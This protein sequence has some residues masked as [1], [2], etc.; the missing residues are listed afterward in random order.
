MKWSTKIKGGSLQ[1]VLFIGAV[2]AVLLLT[3]VLLSHMHIQFSKKSDTYIETIKQADL[4]L[5]MVLNNSNGGLVGLRD[6][7]QKGI[8]TDVVQESWG[9][10]DLYRIDASFRKTRFTK[11]ALVGT[12]RPTNDA[13][14]YLKDNQRPMIIV[15]HARIKGDAYLPDQG[16][17]HGNISGQSFYGHTLVQGKQQRSNNTLP[18]I[19]GQLKNNLE[20]WVSPGFIPAN[21]KRLNGLQSNELVHSFLE[22]PLVVWG[23][24]LQ[25]AGKKITGNVILKA[26]HRIVVS[27]TTLLTDVVLV[28]PEI[29][30]QD[31]VTGSF[32]AIASKTIVVGKNCLLHYPSALAVFQKGSHTGQDQGIPEPNI[33]IQANSNLKGIVGY[34]E[35]GREQQQRYHPQVRIDAGATVI[36]QVYCEKHLELKGSVHGNVTTDSFVALEN[37]SIYQ[38]HLYQGKIDA[39]ALPLQYVGLGYGQQGKGG[40]AKWLY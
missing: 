35:D 27:P 2:I 16:I 28:A 18:P 5:E 10:L 1:F 3:F 36:G 38:N 20:Q 22:P 40:V 12:R 32:Q 39:R 14:L 21:S 37:G 23:E 19:A 34:W 25:L 17:R 15:G 13:A 26:D 30:I 33:Q 7:S 11:M 9:L 4:T 24:V 8:E 29:M 31:G 6:P